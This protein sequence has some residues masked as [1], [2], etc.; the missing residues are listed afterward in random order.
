MAS[1]IKHYVKSNAFILNDL[2]SD[3][4]EKYKH[5]VALE[6]CRRM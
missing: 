2:F 3:L 4:F 1:I 5:L 6:E